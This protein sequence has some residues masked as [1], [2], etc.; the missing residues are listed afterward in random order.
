M[1]TESI[2]EREEQERRLLW[3]VYEAARGLCFGKDWNQ[4]EE[5][6]KYRNDLI[7]AVAAVEPLPWGTCKAKR[8]FVTYKIEGHPIGEADFEYKREEVKVVKC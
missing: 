8:E 3:N 4:G 1:H 2:S 7:D 5:T 6:M